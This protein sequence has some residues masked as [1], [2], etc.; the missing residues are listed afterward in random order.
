MRES[1]LIS[2]VER[3]G[4]RYV[5]FFENDVWL[6]LNL[7]VQIGENPL[8]SGEL[9]TTGVLRH[10]EGNVRLQV[11]NGAFFQEPAGVKRGSV[12]DLDV[13]HS[14]GDGDLFSDGLDRVRR[15]H[16]A[17]KEV[18]FGLLKPDFLRSLNPQYPTH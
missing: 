7:G 3:I 5:D 1:G 18:F 11:A 14:G 4:L 10:L 16:Q 15:L 6:Q 8:T 13:W 9:S 2:E 12:L 17:S